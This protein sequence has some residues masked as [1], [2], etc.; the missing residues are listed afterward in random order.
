MSWSVIILFFFF[1]SAKFINPST[2]TR[3]KGEQRKSTI[4][5][6]KTNRPRTSSNGRTTKTTRKN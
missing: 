5:E 6:T 3:S 1:E 2:L 4:W